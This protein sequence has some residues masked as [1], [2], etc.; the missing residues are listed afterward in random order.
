MDCMVESSELDMI[1]ATRAANIKIVLTDCDGVLTDGTVYY[2]AR[3]EE[4]RRFSVLD[5]MGVELLRAHGIESGIIS[6]ETSECILR[7][8]EKLRLDP[9]FLGVRLKLDRLR[10]F[11]EDSGIL[12]ENVAYIGDDVNDLSLMRL[13]CNHGLTA[14]PFGA[15]AFLHPFAHYQTR[16]Q[17]GRGAFR[18]FADLILSLSGHEPKDY[19]LVFSTEELERE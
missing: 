17:G 9:V 2:S 19:P 6:G 1:L 3:G 12:L 5:G 14:C 4:M 16:R 8:A 13:L 11:V 18:E 7:R 10:R 15:T